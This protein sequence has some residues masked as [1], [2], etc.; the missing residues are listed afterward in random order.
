MPRSLL[1]PCVARP[2]PQRAAASPPHAGS[3]PWAFI[4][5]ILSQDSLQGKL[6][7]ISGEGDVAQTNI[8]QGMLGFGKKKALMEPMIQGFIRELYPILD[9]MGRRFIEDKLWDG[10]VPKDSEFQKML[11][12]ELL[13]ACTAHSLVLTPNPIVEKERSR[14]ISAH[15]ESLIRLFPSTGFSY[16]EEDLR[17]YLEAH[18]KYVKTWTNPMTRLFTNMGFKFPIQHPLEVFPVVLYDRLG[19]P[20]EKGGFE[21]YPEVKNPLFVEYWNGSFSRLVNSYWSGAFDKFDIK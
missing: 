21:E 7:R 2:S 15:I 18:D 10:L 13:I 6:L 9:K 8:N 11:T 19:I 5:H 1:A 4:G 20:H 16:S 3:L 14:W 17:C 12:K